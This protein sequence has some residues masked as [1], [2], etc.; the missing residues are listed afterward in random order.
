M[1]ASVSEA[2]DANVMRL[3]WKEEHGIKHYSNHTPRPFLN[4]G[5]FDLRTEPGG[6]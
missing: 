2:A 3:K 1:S 5:F 4:A 6:L